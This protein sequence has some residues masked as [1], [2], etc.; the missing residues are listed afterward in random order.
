ME[1][2]NLENEH[3]NEVLAINRAAANRFGDLSQVAVVANAGTL[4]QG[5]ETPPPGAEPVS[6]SI[7][8]D[9]GED[10]SVFSDNS[11]RNIIGSVLLIVVVLLGFVFIRRKRG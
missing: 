9:F 4:H 5:N 11:M 2:T 3:K 10:T 7:P 8:F 1:Y 6:T